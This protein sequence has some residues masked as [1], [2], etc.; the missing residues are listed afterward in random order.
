M[1]HPNPRVGA[2]VVSP[3]GDVV[4]EG[5]HEG[6]GTPHAEVVALSHAGDRAR[7]ATVYVTLEPCNHHGRTPP[8]VDALIDARV[9]AVV[10]AV[11]DPD[12]RTDGAGL[13]RLRASGISVEVGLSAAEA[14]ATDPAYFHHLST[15]MPLVTW[16]Y[17]M[18]LDGAVAAVDGSSQWITSDEARRDVHL[19]RSRMDAVVVGSGTLAADDP[20]LDVRLEGFEGRQPVPVVV[21]GESEPDSRA[22]IWDRRPLVFSTRERQLPG[23]E[24]VVVTG[25]NHPDP[26]EV[27][28]SLA[29]RGLLDVM[30]EGGPTL[31]GEWWRSGVIDRGATYLGARIG[32][33][34]GISPLAGVFQ[35]IGEAGIVSVS[36]VRS[37]GADI[38]IDWTKDVHGDR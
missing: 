15:G 10:A 3:D 26:R 25:G 28:R 9:G 2:V 33:G 35:S 30:I 34:Q 11:T 19:L 22:R 27:C 16:K 21:L 7:G 17:A 14:V 8:C 6:P 23:G 32:G 24:L 4:G 13:E 18:T 5:W 37:L 29:G 36:Q 38:R 20:R 12:P 1:T 31:A